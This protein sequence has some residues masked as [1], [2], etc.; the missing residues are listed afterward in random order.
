MTGR[1]LHH[2]R[3][4]LIVI[5]AIFVAIIGSAG[6]A[7]AHN[8]L[9][10]STPEADAVLTT[11]P[12]TITLMFNQEVE[13]FDPEMAIT[14]GTDKSVVFTP[15]VN[16]RDVVGYLTTAPLIVPPIG[17][18]LTT[19][20]IGY[21]IVSADG[22]PVTGLVTFF[23][24]AAEANAPAVAHVSQPG[25]SGPPW[26]FWLTIAATLLLLSGAVIMMPKRRR[27]I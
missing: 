18:T 7:S 10:S 8:V 21:R 25:A 2:G 15:T 22:H 3:N 17:T 13:N 1:P 9:V 5:A 12:T 11:A 16:G 23:V 24:G 26:W 4:A 14:I 19:W 27:P 6:P 20:K